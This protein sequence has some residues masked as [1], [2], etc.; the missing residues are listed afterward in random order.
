MGPGHATL[1]QTVSITANVDIGSSGADIFEASAFAHYTWPTIVLI[2][3]N[4]HNCQSPVSVEADKNF[5]EAD[6]YV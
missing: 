3:D 5:E 2:A 1:L 4:H 6:L